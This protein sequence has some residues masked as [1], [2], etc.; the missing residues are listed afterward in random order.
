MSS[1]STRSRAW[2][3]G[4][5]FAIGNLTGIEVFDKSR[6][7]AVLVSRTTLHGS[8]AQLRKLARALDRAADLAEATAA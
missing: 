2:F 7:G 6:I 3:P 4:R 5:L 1:H 8:P